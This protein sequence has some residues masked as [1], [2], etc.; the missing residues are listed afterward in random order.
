MWD[1]VELVASQ[2]RLGLRQ[3][4]NQNQIRDSTSDQSGK[5]SRSL[6]VTMYNFQKDKTNTFFS[7]KETHSLFASNVVRLCRVETCCIVL[8][9]RAVYRMPYSCYCYGV[10][11]CINSKISLPCFFCFF[12]IQTIRKSFVLSVPVL[13]RKY[14]DLNRS[15]IIQS[16][17]MMMMAPL[18]W[19]ANDLIP[20]PRPVIHSTKKPSHAYYTNKEQLMCWLLVVGVCRN[21][22]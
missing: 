6:R 14:K 2:G 11:V 18:L 4:H 5:T 16:Q 12:V 13:S 9:L 17:M 15:K 21:R 7:F 1:P 8:R 20:L 10:A 3:A 19:I 22:G